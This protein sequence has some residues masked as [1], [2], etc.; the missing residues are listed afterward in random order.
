VSNQQ[1]FVWCHGSQP[2]IYQPQSRISVQ[3]YVHTNDQWAIRSIDCPG[4]GATI[5][6]TIIQGTTIAICDGSYKYQFGAAGFMIQNGF[7]QEL[8][9]LGANVTPGHPDEQN[10][11]QSEIGGIAVIVIVAEALT[12]LYEIQSKTVEL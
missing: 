5:A 4:T 1:T 12:A 10:L 9:I 3:D 8:R 11:Y 2:L 6:Q 7:S